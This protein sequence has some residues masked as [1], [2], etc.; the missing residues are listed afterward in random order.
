M[1]QDGVAGRAPR[2][3]TI[4]PLAR[5]VSVMGVLISRAGDPGH[6]RESP[7]AGSTSRR[8]S[9]VFFRPKAIASAGPAEA[10]TWT[11]VVGRTSEETTVVSWKMR[12][13]T[14]APGA[15]P[16][17][18]PASSK[19]IVAVSMPTKLVSCG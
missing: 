11:W 9:L 17:V 19:H 2:P 18:C 5:S 15:G 4:D 10:W 12:P 7:L 1:V 3:C 8:F 16:D 13:M 14:S 6:S